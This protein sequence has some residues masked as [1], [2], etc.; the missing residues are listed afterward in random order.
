LRVAGIGG[1]AEAS[2]KTEPFMKPLLLALAL[3]AGPALAEPASPADMAAL[4]A[5]ANAADSAWNEKNAARMAEAYAEDGTLR[6]SG[7]AVLEGRAAI[8]TTFDRN[9]AARQGTM[10]HVT[11]V[12]RAELIAPDLAFTD[13]GVR[14]EQQQPDGSWTLMR[15]FRNVSVARR[16][17]GTWKLQSVRAFLVPNPS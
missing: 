13:A 6:M 2:Q 17:G 3:F 14:V 15:S 8:R 1:S 10:R 7:G 4:Q 12:D 11:A 16:E 9:F 5:L